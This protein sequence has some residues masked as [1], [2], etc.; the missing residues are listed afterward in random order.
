MFY[1][2]SKNKKKKIKAR[3]DMVVHTC[4]LSY[5]QEVEVGG[6]QTEA[7]PGKK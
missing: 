6:S 5:V 2:Q 1:Q 4:N 7:S 3:L